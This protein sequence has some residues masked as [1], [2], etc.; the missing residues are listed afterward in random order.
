VHPSL[1]PEDVEYIASVV[2]RL[3]AGNLLP[4]SIVRE[5]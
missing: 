1:G 4:R 3:G 5:L 2:N